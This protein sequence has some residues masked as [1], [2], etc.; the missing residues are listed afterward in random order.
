MPKIQHENRDRTEKEILESI[1]LLRA[2]E[3]PIT[4]VANPA[5][6]Y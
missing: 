3:G 6:L 2:N 5:P 1:R 4:V